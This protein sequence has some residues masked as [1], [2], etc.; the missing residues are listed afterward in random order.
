MAQ[1]EF[2]RENLI[3][4]ARILERCEYDLDFRNAVYTLCQKDM[5]FWVNNFCFTYDPRSDVSKDLPFVLFEKQEAY[6]RWRENVVE[7]KDHGVIEKSRDMG[8]SWL[9]VAHQVHQWLFNPGFK[10]TFGS[11]K[12]EY[13]DELNN[14]DSLLEKVRYI[15]RR[16]PDWMKPSQ[17]RLNYLKIVNLDNFSF[18]TG[19]I[20]SD[21]GRGGRSTFYDADEFAF[22]QNA[23]AA[24]SG[25]S[26]NTETAFYTSTPNGNDN[27]YYQK[28]FSGKLPV[29][30]FN[31]YDHPGKDEA[32]LEEQK[33]KLDPIVVAREILIDYE[34]SAEGVTIPAA[35]VRAAVGL[36]VRGGGTRVSALDVADDGPD[37]NVYMHR[38][39]VILKRIERWERQTT[40]QTAHKA[41]LHCQ[42]DNAEFFLYDAN[43]VGAGVTGDMKAMKTD[44]RLNYEVIGL[45]NS[46]G[47]T[48]NVYPKFDNKM[49]K[50][51]FA[52]LRAELY[53]NLRTR[54]ER[55]YEHAEGI[56]FYDDDELISIPDDPKLTQ[57]LSKPK[58]FFNSRGLI[59]IED[60]RKMTASPDD[61]DAATMLFAPTE[62]VM[63]PAWWM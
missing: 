62:M 32:W 30:T 17:Y 2:P 49:G 22:L 19:E 7:R 26:Q 28:R 44:G 56:N 10:G 35:W 21:T 63:K 13:V 9:N 45:K 11:R 36:F 59:Q 25:I 33:R 34:G 23:E 8:V 5:V 24:D 51:I 29:F 42:E 58:F 41:N 57:T 52:N 43:G 27:L 40:F 37:K 6:L 18:I 39:G 12:K 60:K 1:V 4:R 20:G 55:T 48:E 14:I 15:I 3:Q 53:W 38:H 31:Y 16:L 47:A 46:Q 54:F 61:A 50:E